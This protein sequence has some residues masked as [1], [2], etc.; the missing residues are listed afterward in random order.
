MSYQ[1]QRDAILAHAKTAALG[2]HA[3]FTDVQIGAAWPSGSKC[4]RLYWGGEAEP[5]H[6]GA[7]RVL[8]GRLIAP[9]VELVGFWAMSTLTPAAV[10]A[11]DDEMT[12]F[13]HKLR[14]AVLGDSQ[15]GGQSS[16]LE[17]GLAEPSDMVVNG[18]RWATVSVLF[19]LDYIEYPLAP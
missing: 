16:D 1:N 3:A 9:T 12:T 15:L 2:T 6:M 5:E 19:T 10:K 13:I 17:M 7:S 4:V 14:T 11:I 18:T 8:N